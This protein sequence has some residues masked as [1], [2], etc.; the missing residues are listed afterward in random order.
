[1]KK[2]L[3][4]LV[5]AIFALSL[6]AVV[7]AADPLKGVVNTLTN[8]TKPSGEATVEK[9]DVKKDKKTKKA[10]KESAPKK[11]ACL[12]EACEWSIVTALDNLKDVI[13]ITSV[14]IVMDGKDSFFTV[15]F[16]IF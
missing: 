3:S 12:G 13:D 11:D 9:K 6:S 10:K 14:Y 16:F 1:M 7:F 2:V 4:I 8:L 5:A 15:H